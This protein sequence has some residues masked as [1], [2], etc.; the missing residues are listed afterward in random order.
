MIYTIST[1]GVVSTGGTQGGSS[2]NINYFGQ[3][4]A[5]LGLVADE[6][7]PPH[8]FLALSEISLQKPATAVDVI[9][10]AIETLTNER[11]KLGAITNAISA[12]QSLML[13]QVVN[14]KDAQSRIIDTDFAQTMQTLIKGQVIQQAGLALLSVTNMS[15]DLAMRL[16]RP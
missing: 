4:A 1:G 14:L 10:Q 8:D 16:L 5:K 15:S 13:T 6:L 9:D 12:K 7:A 11:A 2:G 3:Q